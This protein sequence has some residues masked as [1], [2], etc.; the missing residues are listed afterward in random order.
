MFVLYQASRP[1][2]AALGRMPG[3]GATFGDVSR[4]TSAALIP[5]LVII[6]LDAP[7]YFF[8]ANVARSQILELV[9]AQES[10]PRAVLID[11]GATADLDVTSADTLAELVAT[12]RSQ[13]VEVLLAQV[14]GTVRDRL[15]K[16]GLMAQVGQERVYLSVG[17]GVS[18]FLRRWPPRSPAGE[19]PDPTAT[20]ADEPPESLATG[21]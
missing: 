9:A 16:M 5:G 13:D 14:R 21:P 3:D 1:Y 17:A 2:V 20:G 6:R 10:A 19:P 18:D 11:L 12:L 8:N 15:L 4:H 7:L